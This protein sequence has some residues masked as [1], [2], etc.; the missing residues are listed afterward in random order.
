M[1]AGVVMLG[2]ERVADPGGK[3]VPERMRGQQVD[4]AAAPPLGQRRARGVQRRGGMQNGGDMGVVEIQCMAS[5]SVHHR[6]VCDAQ[7]VCGAE[8]HRLRVT[9]ENAALVPGDAWRPVP[10]RLQSPDQGGRAGIGC[11]RAVHRPVSHRRACAK[12]SPAAS[13]SRRRSGRRSPTGLWPCN[14]YNRNHFRITDSIERE[15]SVTDEQAV[16]RALAGF[17]AALRIDDLPADV[18]HQAVRCLVDWLGCTIAGSATAEGERVRAGIGALDAGT[19]HAPRPSWAPASAPG[20]ATPRWPTG[21]PRMCSISTTPST[22]TGPRST[23]ALRCGPPLSRPRNSSRSPAWPRSRRSS[24]ASKSRPGSPSPPG[25][26]TTTPAGTSPAPS[27]TSGPPRRPHGCLA[28]H[29]SRRSP[30]SEPAPPRR[31]G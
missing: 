29:P 18:V 24:Q 10:R 17:A 21:S 7:P 19:D 25:R 9:A 8:R 15:R 23:A 28:F 16:S 2:I 3:L 14:L 31:R 1:P 26:D 4:T 27:D 13:A 22:P 20:R 6:G 5:D 11:S 30:R 12:R